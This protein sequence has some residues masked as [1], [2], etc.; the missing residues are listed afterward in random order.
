M[1]IPHSAAELARATLLRLN[2]LGLPPTPDN[3]AKYYHQLDGEHQEQS[4]EEAPPPPREGAC[5][6]LVPLVR[7]FLQAISD[8]ADTL[9]SSLGTSNAQIRKSID[10][11]VA[12]QDQEEVLR[13]LNFIITKANGIHAT[14]GNT[15]E[16]LVT[17]RSALDEIK[18]ELEETRQL[19]HE[20]ALTGAQNRRAMDAV[21]A[22]EVARSKRM[23]SRLSVAMI[24]IDHFKDVNDQ[25]GHDAGDRLLLHLT[26]I[27][28]SV[29]RESDV[30]VRYGGEEFLVILPDSDVKGAE[31]VLDRLKSVIR[32]SPL[33]Y[34]NKKIDITFSGGIAQ[35]KADE[36]GHA[37]ILR[38]DAALYEAKRAGRN[39]F[40]VS[41]R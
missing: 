36:N 7:T 19:L 6:E 20:D 14:V 34:E 37:L 18:A 39:C 33:I 32:R 25:H 12:A 29:L 10:E 23:G 8:K 38:A 16:D 30:L 31:F 21:L 11:L 2:E 28:K 4:V 17:T 41:S 3:Y 1:D 24:D 35:L 15:Y 13:L 22:K 40:R 5:A 9:A 27:A 26:M